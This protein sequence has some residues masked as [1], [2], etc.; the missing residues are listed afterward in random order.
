MKARRS[1]EDGAPVPNT[2]LVLWDIDHT[3]I[4]TGGV[5]REIHQE[6]FEQV[7]RKRMQR[8]ADIS[9]R[10]EPDIFCDTLALRGIDHSEEAPGPRQSVGLSRW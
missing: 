3:L 6:A 2:R 4:D 5:G 8:Q 10:T 1:F 9:R 7:T